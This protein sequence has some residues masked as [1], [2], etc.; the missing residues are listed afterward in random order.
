MVSDDELDTFVNPF[1]SCSS[2]P[3]AAMDVSSILSSNATHGSSPEQSSAQSPDPI[4][5][6]MHML[7]RLHP[8]AKPQ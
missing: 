8:L 7:P 2:P 3:S 1:A 5:G 4:G 6:L